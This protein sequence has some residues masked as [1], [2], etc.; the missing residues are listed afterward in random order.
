MLEPEVAAL[1]MQ[2]EP[3]CSARLVGHGTA[4]SV[5]AASGKLVF[6]AAQLQTVIRDGSKAILCKFEELND[7]NVDMCDGLLLMNSSMHR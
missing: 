1:A 5:G 7:E 3:N 4:V 2:C 6:N